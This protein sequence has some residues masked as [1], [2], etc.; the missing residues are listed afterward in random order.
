VT[1]ADNGTLA[2]EH[3]SDADGRARMERLVLAAR[4]GRSGAFGELVTELTPM[5]WHVARATGLQAPDA[6]D[7]LQNV[8]LSLVSH[9]D[10]IHTPAALTSWLITTTRREAWRTMSVGRR[11]HPVDQEWFTTIPDAGSDAEARLIMKDE[12]RELWEAFRRLPGRCQKLLRI[13]A[14]VPR[15]DYDVVAARL[16]MARGSVGPT[17][18][19]CL[20]KLRLALHGEE[21]P[22]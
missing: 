8:W 3:V 5:L 2:P 21:V 1:V 20:D 22:R 9:L 18:G 17:R 13:V 14:F 19:R 16:G 7:V 4:Q 15:P 12:Q 11:Q 10:T 6:E